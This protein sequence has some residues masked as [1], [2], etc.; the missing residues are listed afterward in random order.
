VLF[1][2]RDLV[3]RC[4]PIAKQM[5][6]IIKALPD[7]PRKESPNLSQTSGLVDI[8]RGESLR[9]AADETAWRHVRSLLRFSEP[10][11][12]LCWLSDSGLIPQLHA[13]L[14]GEQRGPAWRVR[15][16]DSIPRPSGRKTRCSGP[17]KPG[18][19]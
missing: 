7:P 5:N 9:G 18:W 13:A 11:H 10:K 2:E 15:R 8:G 3:K 4:R 17:L 16:T 6:L 1:G 14:Q 19:R 12:S